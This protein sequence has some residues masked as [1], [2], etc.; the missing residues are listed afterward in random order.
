MKKPLTV[1]RVREILLSDGGVDLYVWWLL[2]L[3]DDQPFETAWA[4]LRRPEQIA[5]IAAFVSCSGSDLQVRLIRALVACARIAVPKFDCLA[6]SEK[7]LDLAQRIEAWTLTRTTKGADHIHDASNQFLAIG[8]AGHPH[9]SATRAGIEAIGSVGLFVGA[10]DCDPDAASCGVNWVVRALGFE[11]GAARDAAVA[12]CVEILR[13]EL[14]YD[15]IDAAVRELDD[16]D[17]SNAPS[18][19]ARAPTVLN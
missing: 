18:P 10:E 7:A 5:W 8:R 14:P 11:G 9:D 19:P 16:D 17:S 3:P 1:A 13:R 4:A 2:D 6:H 15:V 12:Q